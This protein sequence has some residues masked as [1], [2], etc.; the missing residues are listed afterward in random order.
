MRRTGYF[1]LALIVLLSTMGI[2]YGYWSP[3]SLPVTEDVITGPYQQ[4]NTAPASSITSE[5]A[6]LNGILTELGPGSPRTN[7]FLYF[8]FGDDAHYPDYNLGTDLEAVPFA[9]S[10]TVPLDFHINLNGLIGGTKYHFRVKASRLCTVVSED[11]SFIANNPLEV[12]SEGATPNGSQAE[13]KGV[14]VDTGQA[15]SV[16]LS[17]EW[18]ETTDYSFMAA[19]NPPSC[20]GD[21]PKIFVATITGLSQQTVYHF[22]ARAEGNDGTVFFGK[23]IVFSTD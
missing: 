18:G 9:S 15:T 19:G 17:F 6:T 11:R 21:A 14:L 8:D 4:A 3:V 16:N 10:G 20:N 23:D 2:V 7:V 13:L 5:S 22:R 1:L 12:I